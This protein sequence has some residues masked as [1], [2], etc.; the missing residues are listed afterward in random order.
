VAS[1]AD[2]GAIVARHCDALVGF[3]RAADA[4]RLADAW[5]TAAADA[6][7]ALLRAEAL[8]EAGDAAAA[9]AATQAIPDSDARRR[10]IAAARVAAGDLAGALAARLPDGA[11]DSPATTIVADGDLGETVLFARWLP[12][13]AARFGP[14]T[15]LVP[16][17][18]ATALAGLGGSVGWRAADAGTRAAAAG[19]PLAAAVLRLGGD[20]SLPV[21]LRPEPSRL[22]RWQRRLGGDGFRVGVAWH[23][24]DPAAALPPIE[25]E[26][27]TRLVGVRLVAIE[28]A[29]AAADLAG[30]AGL[31]AVTDLGGLIPD[32]PDAAADIV[33][34]LAQ[35]DA[36]VAVDA[37]TAHLAAALGK[38]VALML[39]APRAA[40]LWPAGTVEQRWYPSLTVFRQSRPGDW[41][42][43]VA[44]VVE[45]IQRRRGGSGPT[46]AAAVAGPAL[47]PGALPVG[48]HFARLAEIAARLAETSDPRKRST[49][50]VE[51]HSLTSGW[52]RLGLDARPLQPLAAALTDL[53]RCR[54]QVTARLAERDAAGDH[55]ADFIAAARL[56]VLLEAEAGRL[57][58]AIDAIGTRRLA[59]ADEPLPAGQRPAQHSV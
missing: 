55:G 32:G 31:A 26:P 34:I 58:E 56:L 36:V 8:L 23:A 33:A 44:A 20:P 39:K 18:L 21:A 27:L 46:P 47:I 24:D 43:P 12:A 17:P 30:E 38:P 15:A 35:L 42:G 11:A 50:I 54:R 13:Y 16:P 25:L 37:A 19:L 52:R 59:A 2:I 49:L 45:W 5:L 41:T 6:P 22:A 3:G 57:Q 29:T 7:V 1:S 10:L 53:A 40:W 28:T 14:V 51:Q 9:L 48:H 4:A